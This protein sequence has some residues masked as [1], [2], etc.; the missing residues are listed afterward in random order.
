MPQI[1]RVTVHAPAKINLSLDIVGKRNDGYH[2]LET[3]MHAINLCDTVTVTRAESR[4][5]CVECSNRDVP[6]DGSNIAYKAAALFFS[7]T[8][9][10][11]IGISIYIEKEIPMQAGLAGGST[12]AAATLIALNH[13]FDTN[14]SETALFGLGEKLGADVPFCIA[15]GCKLARGKGE[16]L[17]DLT[18]LPEFTLLIAKPSLGVSTVEAFANYSTYSGTLHRPDTTAMM[19]AITNG[20]VGAIGKQMLNVFEQLTPI[21]EVQTI[22][23]AMKQHGAAGAVM[24][25]SGSAVAGLFADEITAR[26][27]YPH[28]TTVADEVFVT[29]PCNSG[30]QIIQ[31]E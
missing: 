15:G 23:N 24:S 4:S 17:T 7:Q 13:M 18:P 5:I 28:M 12:D 6:E 1:K 10:Q 26:S 21:S 27:C 14:L 19:N 31:C 30:V 9:I 29:T 11:N 22:K 8:G 25:G 2:E 20:D 3:V 16:L